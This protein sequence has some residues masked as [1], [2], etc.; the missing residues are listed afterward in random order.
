MN[1]RTNQVVGL[2]ALIS[3]TRSKGGFRKLTVGKFDWREVS[4]MPVYDIRN[5]P[6]CTAHVQVA[7]APGEHEHT[8]C[9]YLDLGGPA[10]VG[11]DH[12]G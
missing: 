2:P 9:F 5:E 8:P 3:H 10:V 4:G 6:Q 7:P 1:G 11:P 12:C